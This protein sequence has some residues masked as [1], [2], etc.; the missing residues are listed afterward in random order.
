[1]RAARCL[2]VAN[3]PTRFVFEKPEAKPMPSY[4]RIGTQ[5]AAVVIDENDPPRV[6]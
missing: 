1:M 3:G 2:R 5:A 6:I 4:D